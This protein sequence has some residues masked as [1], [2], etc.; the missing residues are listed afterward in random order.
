[1]QKCNKSNEN[2]QNKTE[3]NIQE[4]KK[5]LLWK[6]LNIF[7]MSTAGHCIKIADKMT[8]NL[9]KYESRGTECE[10]NLKQL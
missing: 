9:N 1:M 7:F 5:N 10:N 3:R 8:K 2:L 4:M 6:I